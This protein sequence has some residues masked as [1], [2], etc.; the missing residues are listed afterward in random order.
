MIGFVKL[1][2]PRNLAWP[3]FLRS[4]EAPASLTLSD[5]APRSK[6][7]HSQR[8]ASA[9]GLSTTVSPSLFVLPCPR[10][11]WFRF[12][13]LGLDDLPRDTRYLWSGI[14]NWVNP[15][16]LTVAR[17][18]AKRGNCNEE[19]PRITG[20]GF[21]ERKGESNVDASKGQSLV[22]RCRYLSTL[23]AH[24]CDRNA[25]GIGDFAGL[26]QRLGYLQELGITAIWLL[27]FY[28]S[29]EYAMDKS[30]RINRGIRRRLAPMMNNDRRRIELLNGLLMSMPGTPIVYYGDEIGMGG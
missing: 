24:F 17:V 23:C 30:M 27:P 22:Q 19:D 29:D 18:G 3:F 14:K 28:P 1:L 10:R 2:S 4:R 6:H 8:C 15:N 5:Q 21:G 12:R 16:L 13:L 20:G 7:T 26:T 25:D 9:N 11:W